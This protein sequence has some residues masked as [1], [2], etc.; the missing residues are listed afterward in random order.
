MHIHMFINI[1]S[2]IHVNLKIQI[3]SNAVRQCTVPLTV[4]LTF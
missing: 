3:R 2:Y 1:H 4:S